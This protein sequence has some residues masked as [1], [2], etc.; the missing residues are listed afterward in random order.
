MFPLKVFAA[1]AKNSI[2]Y[3]EFICIFTMPK[4]EKATEPKI[5]S[6]SSTYHRCKGFIY[7]QITD[8]QFC[9]CTRF[10]K[11]MRTGPSLNHIFHSSQRPRTGLQSLQT[12]QIPFFLFAILM[13]IIHKCVE[14][15][16]L[17]LQTVSTRVK[18]VQGILWDQSGDGWL[19]SCWQIPFNRRKGINWNFNL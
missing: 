8:Q 1:A 11:C 14:L 18:L 19:S 16:N 12:Q 17:L 5:Q 13:H 3:R 10:P 7:N 2:D 15:F 4:S 9:A 6:N